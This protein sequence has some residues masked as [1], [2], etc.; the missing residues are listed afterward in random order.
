MAS[1]VSCM[2]SPRR[3]GTM[4]YEISADPA[5]LDLDVI[6]RYLSEEAYWSPGVPRAIV[7]RAV[8]NS[9]C[10]GVYAADGGQVGFARLVTDRATFAYLAD[11]FVLTA[12]RGRGLSK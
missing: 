8:E 11:V 4:M 10:F 6:Y 3:A 7:E 2:P 12:H 1:R 9:L 5:R